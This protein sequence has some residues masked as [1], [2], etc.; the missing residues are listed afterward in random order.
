MASLFFYCGL[1]GTYEDEY[2]VIRGSENED[3][4]NLGSHDGHFLKSVV[5][6]LV[7]LM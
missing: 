4:N 7:A 3:A 5:I 6:Y 2:E 1:L